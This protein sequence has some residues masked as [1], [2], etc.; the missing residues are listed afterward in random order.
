MPP[1]RHKR[2]QL[3]CSIPLTRMKKKKCRQFTKVSK[4]LLSKLYE[5]FLAKRE[6]QR[7]RPRPF[8]PNDILIRHLLPRSDELRR[9]AVC[10]ASPHGKKGTELMPYSPFFDEHVLEITDQTSARSP[11]FPSPK[12]YLNLVWLQDFPYACVCVCMCVWVC[13]GYGAQ[14]ITRNDHVNTYR[15]RMG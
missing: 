14:E 3:D 13:I 12:A 4:V 8:W 7:E 11:L 1:N 6:T 2:T 10:A 5:S 9:I 15:R